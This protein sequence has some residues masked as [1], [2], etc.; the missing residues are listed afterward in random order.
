MKILQHHPKGRPHTQYKF[1]C[2]ATKKK[3]FVPSG[4]FLF[5]EKLANKKFSSHNKK[6]S[7]QFLLEMQL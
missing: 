1:E 5:R 2:A 7:L 3:V 4:V 6:I